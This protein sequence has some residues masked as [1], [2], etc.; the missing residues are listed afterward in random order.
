MLLLQYLRLVQN[1]PAA[2]H[3]YRTRVSRAKRL[4]RTQVLRQLKTEILR[5]KFGIDGKS[6]NQIIFSQA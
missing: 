3:K 4:Q 5:R 6:R 1:A 2:G